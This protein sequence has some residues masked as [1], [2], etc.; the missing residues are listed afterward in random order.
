M[1]A[2][3]NKKITMTTKIYNYANNLLHS[4]ILRTYSSIGGKQLAKTPPAI[5]HI[6]RSRPSVCCRSYRGHHQSN[7]PPRHLQWNPQLYFLLCQRTQTDSSDGTSAVP[8]I[9]QQ[10]LA[11]WRNGRFRQRPYQ[12]TWPNDSAG[13]L[14]ART[15]IYCYASQHKVPH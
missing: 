5:S 12:R 10:M 1:V 11:S 14:L 4:R 7:A 8:Y 6:F 2:S 13:F 15:V 9:V 3:V